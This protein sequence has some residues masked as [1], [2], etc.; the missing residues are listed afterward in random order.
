M[1]NPLL[2]YLVY[3]IVVGSFLASLPHIIS[4]IKERKRSLHRSP[5]ILINLSD[6]LDP[7]IQFYCQLFRK[8]K[9]AGKHSEWYEDHGPPI[10]LKQKD[11]QTYEIDLSHIRNGLKK[12][13]DPF[14]FYCVVNSDAREEVYSVLC[15]S[16]IIVTGRGEEIEG[17]GKWR[18][19]FLAGHEKIHS[20]I[21]DASRIN[22]RL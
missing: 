18:V 5:E 14:K 17:E 19:W 9:N 2:V 1:T 6:T 16:G 7:Q 11:N 22:H 15:K 21:Q 20:K 13:N 4:Y 8:R 3:P 10:L 12:F